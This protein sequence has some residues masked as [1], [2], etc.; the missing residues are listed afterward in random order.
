LYFSALFWAYSRTNKNDN[1]KLSLVC[2]SW[3]L[4]QLLNGNLLMERMGIHI[5]LPT[6]GVI[7]AD[8]CL[9]VCP[10]FTLRSIINICEFPRAQIFITI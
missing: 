6:L 7:K 4:T 10:S 1:L 3:P 8:P 2:L 5:L 9:S